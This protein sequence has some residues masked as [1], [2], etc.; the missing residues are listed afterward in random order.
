MGVMLNPL[1][2]TSSPKGQPRRIAP[3][4]IGSDG[5][6][7]S[8]IPDTLRLSDIIKPAEPPQKR[9]KFGREKQAAD[10]KEP[11]PVNEGFLDSPMT[12]RRSWKWKA[13]IAV[14][15][16]MFAAF[17]LGDKYSG[18]KAT[19][20]AVDAGV[21]TADFVIHQLKGKINVREA[22]E[23]GVT[24]ARPLKFLHTDT[25]GL[26]AKNEAA[27]QAKHKFPEDTTRVKEAV[28]PVLFGIDS[29]SF[30]ANYALRNAIAIRN[31]PGMA[32][33]DR[34]LILAHGLLKD[35]HESYD[36][37]SELQDVKL[38]DKDILG[39]F[40]KREDILRK[41][42]ADL[43][44][45]LKV[46]IDGMRQ[47]NG[48]VTET[49]PVLP[50]GPLVLQEWQKRALEAELPPLPTAE[51]TR[52]SQEAMDRAMAQAAEDARPKTLGELSRAQRPATPHGLTTRIQDSEHRVEGIS[53]K[54][55]AAATENTPSP[56]TAAWC[57]VK[58][59]VTGE[60]F[61][62]CVL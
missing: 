17:T 27:I 56:W 8:D 19:L 2:Y 12:L 35:V 59:R 6:N 55:R 54:M 38:N 34:G 24:I 33:K 3:F 30:M 52:R 25:D 49:Q 21:A 18:G 5:V 31:Y 51:E 10:K 43:Q 4:V 9:L 58:T 16:L 11:R 28:L 22:I 14:P 48:M 57:H 23:W 46:L 53:G 1:P 50:K 13:A 32:V 36:A 44:T 41:M 61:P 37:A 47:A 15:P 7:V 26:L 62:K 40:A 39:F 20:Q 29:K 45:G 60:S 42:P